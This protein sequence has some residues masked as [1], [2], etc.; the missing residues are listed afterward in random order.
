MIYLGID[1]SCDDTSI[2]V[3]QNGRVLAN[4][5]SSQDAIHREWG[6]VVPMLAKR[7]HEA[8]FPRVYKL[9]LQRAGLLETDLDAIAVTYGPGLAPA[10]EVGVTL[11]QELATRLQKPLYGV[12]HMEAHLL[13]VL[14]QTKTG[15]NGQIADQV[16]FPVLGVLVSG[17]HTEMAL[18]HG[19]G[20]YEII[21]ETVDDAFGEAYDKVARMLSLGYPGGALL[22][23]LADQ[24]NPKAFPLPTAMR[25]SGDL[26]V[27]YSG[28]KTATLKLVKTETEN[29][30]KTLSLTQIQNIAASF[31]EAALKT[32]LGKV[33][34][35]LQAHPEIQAVWLGGGAAVN[36]Q[37][38]KRLRQ[39]AMKNGLKLSTPYTTKLCRDN[40]AM[41]ALVAAIHE[42]IPMQKVEKLDRVP[43]LRLDTADSFLQFSPSIN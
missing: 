29:G 7:A 32:L 14:A 5:I 25:Q 20:Q 8:E 10:L 21:G 38:R 23:R 34:K 27:S 18:V 1:T 31:Q 30:E 11:A 12:N 3:V 22:A 13:S 43:Q 2:G 15:K 17:G 33:E 26:N 39:L 28:L 41:V 6:G 24:G 16:Q 36:T 4:I 19:F 40:G 42:H 37:L 9:A 35:A